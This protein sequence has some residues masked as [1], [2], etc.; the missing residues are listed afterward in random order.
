MFTA[1]LGGH[2][3][4]TGDS[5]HQQ[6]TSAERTHDRVA[7]ALEDESQNDLGIKSKLLRVRAEWCHDREHD[8]VSRHCGKGPGLGWGAGQAQRPSYF[9][10]CYFLDWIMGSQAFI[11]IF[12]CLK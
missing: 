6:E 7:C 5:F 8:G 11:M 9:F 4:G 3:P 2:L 1:A 10:T 12:I